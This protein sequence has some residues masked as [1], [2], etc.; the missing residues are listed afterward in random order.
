MKWKVPDIKR[1]GGLNTLQAHPLQNGA[2]GWSLERQ[3]R[4][5]IGHICNRNV[6]EP[7]GAQSQPGITGT[8]RDHHELVFRQPEDGAVVN[9]TPFIVA[10]DVSASAPS[11]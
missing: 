9:H 7:K 3:C 1:F 2:G 5:L 6:F 11:T 4:N 10:P 8:A